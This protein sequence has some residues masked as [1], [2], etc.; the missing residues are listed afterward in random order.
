MR[1][2]TGY[3][4]PGRNRGSILPVQQ[5]I[6]CGDICISGPGIGLPGAGYRSR[7]AV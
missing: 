3:G 4:R 5:T 7:Y 1:T 2:C 6:T